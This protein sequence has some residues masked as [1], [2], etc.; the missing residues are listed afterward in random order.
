MHIHVYAV[1]GLGPV[2]GR[3][4]ACVYMY[5]H[6]HTHTHVYAVCGLGPVVGQICAC[7]YMYLHTHTH[8]YTRVHSIW[9][10][11][12]GGAELRG[13]ATPFQKD[14]ANMKKSDVP[15]EL[16]NK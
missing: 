7:V 15:E 13:P 11:A 6:T 9:L 12:G 2:V 8:A 10:G 5:L 14:G 16:I 3:I 4:C 1:C